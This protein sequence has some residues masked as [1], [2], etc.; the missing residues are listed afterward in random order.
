MQLLLPRFCIIFKK[1]PRQ[2][3]ILYCLNAELLKETQSN[4]LSVFDYSVRIRLDSVSTC[5]Q[6]RFYGIIVI[7]VSHGRGKRKVI[8][9]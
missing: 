5:N 8:F 1:D 9:S 4:T 2:Y 3:V 7:I 6:C